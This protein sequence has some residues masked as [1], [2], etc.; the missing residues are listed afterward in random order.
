MREM[1]A[2]H[3]REPCCLLQNAHQR[4]NVMPLASDDAALPL[5][6]STAQQ[7]PPGQSP[8]SLLVKQHAIALQRRSEK[9]TACVEISLWVQTQPHK[10]SCQMHIYAI[11]PCPKQI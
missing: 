2:A 3:H 11:T 6:A 10:H 1:N 5:I 9:G 8:A 4:K 7:H